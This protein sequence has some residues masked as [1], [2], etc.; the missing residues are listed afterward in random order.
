MCVKGWLALLLVATDLIPPL[1]SILQLVPLPKE[2]F[3]R[4]KL[5]AV[6]FANLGGAWA[7]E[8]VA[9]AAQ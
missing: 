7:V 9:R 3:F 4:P 2:H 5:L 8:Q 1:R 6:L